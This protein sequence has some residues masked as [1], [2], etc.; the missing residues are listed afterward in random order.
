P[1]DTV[2]PEA[3][4]EDA[5]EAGA[6]AADDTFDD[7][8]TQEHGALQPVEAP[9]P[10]TDEHLPEIDSDMVDDESSSDFSADEDSESWPVEADGSETED[11]LPEV[12][13]EMADATSKDLL[14]ADHGES[15]PVDA[16]EP[17]P[18]E[19]RREVDPDVADASSG[20]LSANEDSA[21]DTAN[22][23]EPEPEPETR[24]EA[25]HEFDIAQFGP[26]GSVFE[27]VDHIAFRKDEPPAPAPTADQDEVEPV[28]L[29]DTAA[30]PE[31]IRPVFPTP[32]QAARPAQD[33]LA[34]AASEN[35]EAPEV[36]DTHADVTNEADRFD[37]DGTSRGPQERDQA[38]A[39]PTDADWPPQ[40]TSETPD[41]AEHATIDEPRPDVQQNHGSEAVA[42]DTSDT[43]VPRVTP[44]QMQAAPLPP[45]SAA[46]A[47][48]GASEAIEAL[49]AKIAALEAQL[50]ERQAVETDVSVPDA[51]EAFD[52][53]ETFD[54]ELSDE[55]ARAV[56]EAALREAEEANA[57]IFATEETILDEATLRE[58]VTDMVREE[59]QGAL[60]ERIT[61]NVRKLVRREIHRAL[62]A[63]ELE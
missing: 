41:P 10:E 23:P 1:V 49:T 22:A 14:E 28:Q 40:E 42:A 44:A 34:E 39:V 55:E 58:L 60:G 29:H 62:A 63:Q 12:D 43:D 25:Q 33:P 47:P 26:K 31:P 36:E 11:D 56:A 59:L 45:D 54:E 17:E 46:I 3:A 21:F 18:D 38:D 27:A 6:D 20:D 37:N 8:V 30:T 5:Q 7:L 32:P 24:T 52:S 4:T 53:P 61:R 2:E 51:L 13:R 57:E 48:D 35:P 16:T 19:F 15:W 50:A 9:E